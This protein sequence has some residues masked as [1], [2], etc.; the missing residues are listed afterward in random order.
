M[1]AEKAAALALAA[2]EANETVAVEAAMTAVAEEKA[3]AESVAAMRRR[4]ERIEAAADVA[5]APLRFGGPDIAGRFESQCQ[6]PAVF[7]PGAWR[8]AEA[9][10]LQAA[11]VAEAAKGRGAR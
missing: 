11:A 9:A 2:A 3:A 8:S 4:I 10:R 6:K 7:G 5:Q 1:V